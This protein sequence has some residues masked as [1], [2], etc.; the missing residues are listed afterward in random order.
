MAMK[1]QVIETLGED[2]LTLPAQIEAGLAANDRL[3]YYFTL[4]QVARSHAD[5]PDQPAS[6]LK[7]ERLA[8]GIGDGALDR[9]VAATHKEGLSYRVP[10]CQQ[11]MAAV[12]EDARRMAAPADPA[13]KER[14]NRLLGALPR[15]DHDLVEGR[16]IDNIT[17]ADSDHGDTLHR[18]VMDL[19]KQLN[20]LQAGL[21]EE[22]I[23]GAAAYHLRETDADLVRAFMVGLNRTAPLKFGHPGLGTTATS[24]GSRLVI[25]NDI[26]TTDAHV[27]VI[28]VEEMNVT[29]TYS[30]VHLERLQ[31]F[32]SLF[33]QF[34]VTWTNPNSSQTAT[35][36]DGAPFFL[37]TSSFDATDRTQ[38]LAYLDHLGSRLVFLI[39]WNRARKQ[40]R[41]FLNGEQ[42]LRLLRW[43]AD[44]N[45]GHRGFLE[46][47]GAHLI[48]G[49]VETTAATSIHLGDRLS[50]VLGEESAFA[51]VQF[52]FK[53]AAEGLLARQSDSLIRDRIRAELLNHLNTAEARLLGIALDH[54]GLIF[55]I[56]TAIRDRV[57]G[58][59][60]DGAKSEGLAKRARHWEHE[61]DTFV[62]EV[63][64]SVRRRPELQPFH[65]LIEAADDS[66][67]QLEE[68]AFLLGLFESKA[69]EW[70]LKSL[71]PLAG[72]IADASQEWVKAVGHAQHVQ[73]HGPR[74][75]ADDFLTA[76]DRLS[77]LEHDADD[78]ERAISLL[79]LKKAT[80][81]RELHLL[82]KIAQ[83]LGEASDSLKHASVVLR[84]HV[85]GDV[86]AA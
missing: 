14:L 36:A 55:E 54:A 69:N 83:G 62:V 7:Q 5:Q 48:W 43:A 37:T 65:R 76:I 25:Q 61:A 64:A 56:A 86:L 45:I 51:F 71:Q 70:T 33:D 44:A 28:H 57:F 29:L 8:A 42:R 50:D 23:E 77:A 38:L 34:A 84:D 46:L 10:G 85:I 82:S 18:L 6:F 4:L 27:I 67:D 49:A 11:M 75:D 59:P 79:A 30:D 74:D 73:R 31:F 66:A 80:D 2:S 78:A 39:D 52:V 16:A 68:V 63:A 13:I 72:I 40:L 53:T 60:G 19:H 20:A 3:K 22:Q 81:F 24:S 1:T 47:G 12:A 15:A 17:R 26:G 21:A 41:G 58:P 32:R 35:L 9:V